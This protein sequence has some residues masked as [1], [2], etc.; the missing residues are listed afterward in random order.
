MRQDGTFSQGGC[1]IAFYEDGPQGQRSFG[2]VSRV[3]EST[4]ISVDQH[5]AHTKS[6][7]AAE[8]RAQEKRTKFVG[9]CTA[10]NTIFVP[11]TLEIGGTVG[12][13]FVKLIE[14]AAIRVHNV[15]PSHAPFSAPTFY[16]YW[17]SCVSMWCC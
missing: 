8:A 17:L 4:R 12:K 3:N 15:P 14:R 6:G 7:A 16:Q 13:D 1:D 10:L 2:D 9:P 11:L 5:R